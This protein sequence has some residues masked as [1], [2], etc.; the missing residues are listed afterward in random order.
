[1]SG[2]RSSSIRAADL[3][4]TEKKTFDA[5]ESLRLGRSRRVAASRSAAENSIKLM[6]G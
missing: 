4:K 2:V 6:F 5:C 1:M 3:P